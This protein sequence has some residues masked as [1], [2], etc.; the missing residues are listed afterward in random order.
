MDV[1]QAKCPT[2]ITHALCLCSPQMSYSEVLV[3]QVGMATIQNTLFTFGVTILIMLSRIISVLPNK[4][5]KQVLRAW[6][7]TT[8]CI[9]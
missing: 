8:T 6:R 1:L 4:H 3:L 9:D 5:S 7:S 2:L